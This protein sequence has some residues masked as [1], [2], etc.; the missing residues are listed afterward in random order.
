MAQVPLGLLGRDTE[1]SA[2][3]LSHVFVPVLLAMLSIAC[4]CTQETLSGCHAHWSW[5]V[6][7]SL[8]P[9]AVPASQLGREWLKFISSFLGEQLRAMETM[10]QIKAFKKARF[11]SNYTS[12]LAGV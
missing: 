9:L 4:L 12:L 5:P 3:G 6:S 10:E 8:I 11:L 1:L 7:V 2:W